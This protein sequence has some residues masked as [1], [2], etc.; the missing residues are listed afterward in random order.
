MIDPGSPAVVTSGNLDSSSCICCVVVAARPSVI[1]V[2]ETNIKSSQLV[3]ATTSFPGPGVRPSVLVVISDEIV[4]DLLSPVF[5]SLSLCCSGC[6]TGS[7]WPSLST[8]SVLSSNKGA[9]VWVEVEM[10][11]NFG[12]LDS[13][14]SSG[15]AGTIVS[16]EL[17]GWPGPN[18]E[19]REMEGRPV[20]VGSSVT[21]TSCGLDVK[22][23]GN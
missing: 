23:S 18:T 15:A 8:A 13:V 17:R 19:I 6:C 1:S 9:L 3:V 10:M 11:E 12:G 14:V 2:T 4:V 21:G 5:V 20:V 7:S 22:T 16:R